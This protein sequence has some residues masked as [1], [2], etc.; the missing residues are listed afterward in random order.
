MSFVNL[1][2]FFYLE[3]YYII[4]KSRGLDL[5]NEKEIKKMKSNEFVFVWL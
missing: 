2:G 1:S 3:F 5:C 4:I